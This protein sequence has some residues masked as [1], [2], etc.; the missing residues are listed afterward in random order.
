MTYQDFSLIYRDH[1][2]QTCQRELG[3]IEY[4]DA[5]YRRAWGWFQAGK[6]AEYSI[7]WA[8]IQ[9]VWQ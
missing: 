6:P 4:V 1:V 3:H 2:L 8:L 5:I 9:A 7:C